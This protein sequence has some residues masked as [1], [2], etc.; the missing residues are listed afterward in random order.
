MTAQEHLMDRDSLAEPAV[1]VVRISRA[2]LPLK[3]P[4]DGADNWSLHPQ[5]FLSLD[6][7]GAAVCPYCGAHYQL[8][9]EADA[10]G[11]NA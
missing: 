9:A 1:R 10:A 3:C 7:T 5:V 8:A 4:G 6:A 2:E 11:S